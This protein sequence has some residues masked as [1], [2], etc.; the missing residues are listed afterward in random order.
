MKAQIENNFTLGGT[1]DP[2]NHEHGH[3]IN[4]KTQN[5]SAVTY[6]LDHQIGR[7]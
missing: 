4:D 3:K 1:T 5:F 7:K 2:C 6:K